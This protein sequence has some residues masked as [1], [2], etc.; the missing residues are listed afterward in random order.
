ML[1]PIDNSDWVLLGKATTKNSFCLQQPLPGKRFT[2]ATTPDSCRPYTI[3]RPQSKF[4]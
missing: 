1:A 4:E 3:S 2:K